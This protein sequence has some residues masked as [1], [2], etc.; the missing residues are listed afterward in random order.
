MHLQGRIVFFAKYGK[1]YLQAVPLK[2]RVQ[3]DA[4]GRLMKYKVRCV[5]CD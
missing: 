5:Q 4:K 2:A 1:E 3:Y